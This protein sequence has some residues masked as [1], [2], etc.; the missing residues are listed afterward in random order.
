MFSLKFSVLKLVERHGIPK[1]IGE[2]KNV[3][4]Y[5]DKEA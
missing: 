2:R 5:Y 1:S 3:R 4:T